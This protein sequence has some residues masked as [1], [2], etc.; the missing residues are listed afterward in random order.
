MAILDLSPDV[1]HDALRLAP[2]QAPHVLI[3][4]GTWWREKATRDRLAR[5]SDVRETAFPEMYLGRWNGLGV[6]YCCAY[7]AARAVE[8]AHVFAAMGTPLV[9]QIGTCGVLVPGIAPG[10]VAVP[11]AAVA[12]DGVSHHYGAGPEVS[13]DAGWRARAAEILRD[14]GA[15]VHETR[16]LTWPSLFAQSDAMC[17]GWAA[18]GLQTVDMEAAA[19]AAVAARFGAA[20]IT[21]LATWDQ[22]DEGRTFLD[23]LSEEAADALRRANVATYETGLRLA[24]EVAGRRQNRASMGTCPGDGRDKGRIQ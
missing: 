5:L 21:L 17:A 7:G 6:A 15:Q 3:L 1:W 4:E 13:F 11:L 24:T 14:G 20:C 19:V 16:H 2:G 23:P 9:I 8:P 18:E 12:R 10:D 22:L